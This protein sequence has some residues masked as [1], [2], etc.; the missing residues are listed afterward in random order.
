MFGSNLRSPAW[1]QDQFGLICQLTCRTSV[2]LTYKEEN[3]SLFFFFLIS[4]VSGVLL[5]T[6]SPDPDKTADCA[7]R[8]AETAQRSCPSRWGPW[9]VHQDLNSSTSSN[10]KELPVTS[11]EKEILKWS[12]DSWKCWGIFLQTGHVAK[13][14][15][16]WYNYTWLIYIYRQ[17][18]LFTYY[19][20]I[21]TGFCM[22]A[23][24][25]KNY[26]KNDIG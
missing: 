17:N 5:K 7:T 1:F 15:T 22:L 21:A 16:T 20:I 26:R 24:L 12:T 23:R 2:T 19:Q 8:S 4:Q 25:K 18:H 3:G 6:C 14:I 13:V 9:D 11:S 10:N